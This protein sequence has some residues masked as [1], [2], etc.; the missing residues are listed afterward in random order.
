ML[1]LPDTTGFKNALKTCL[2]NIL[3]QNFCHFNKKRKNIFR[4]FNSEN[5]ID[6]F[7]LRVVFQS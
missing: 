5:H 2:P 1:R 6:P 7:S 4:N 3:F